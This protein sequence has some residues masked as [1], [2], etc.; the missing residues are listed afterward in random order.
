MAILTA[1]HPPAR[2]HCCA[3]W[4]AME[5]IKIGIILLNVNGWW[6]RDVPGCLR[7]WLRRRTVVRV[8]QRWWWRCYAR[9]RSAPESDWR[10]ATTEPSWAGCDETIRRRLDLPVRSPSLE[11]TPRP[12]PRRRCLRYPH[13]LQIEYG[14]RR[15]ITRRVG[16]WF[17]NGTSAHNR[18]YD[19]VSTDVIKM[20]KYNQGYLATIKM[21]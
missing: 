1:D 12:L 10:C 11:P 13:I 9:C 5:Q 8:C 7:H 2:A 18:P 4:F 19:R 20:W 21:E 15:G 6:M 3:V 14:T 17:L 16:E